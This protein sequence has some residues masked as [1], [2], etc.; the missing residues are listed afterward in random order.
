MNNFG[1]TLLQFV[2]FL[3]IIVLA[4]MGEGAPLFRW[5]TYGASILMN[6]AL[7]LIG[8]VLAVLAL[9][10]APNLPAG[11]QVPFQN[12]G[13]GAIIL[14]AGLVG[15][16]P[17]VPAVRRGL[18]RRIPIDPTHTVHTTALVFAIYLVGLTSA[19]FFVDF[20]QLVASGVVLTPG[21]AWAQSLAFILFGVLGV[22]FGIRRSWSETLGRLGLTRLT[23][24]QVALALG[25]MLVLQLFDLAV[26]YAW[27][28][29]APGSFQQLSDITRGLFRRFAGPLG[30]VTLGLSAGLGEEILFRG[31]VQPRFGLWLTTLL[32]ALGHAQYAISP[33]LAEVFVIGL[34]LGIVR[35]RENTSTAI[36]I[37][38]TYNALNV[39]MVP[40]APG[41]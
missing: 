40:L 36:L 37:H 18:A 19:Q 12:P 31:A 2:P 35:R 15:F 6:L 34:I 28:A 17:L 13:A 32:F 24:R 11:V 38:A 4:N 23:G 16:L 30:A 22:G 41:P 1:A 25:I 9:T 26:S 14:A 10:P 3:I 21:A 27:F 29:V 8:G 20:R 7:I 33:A 39:L 5:L